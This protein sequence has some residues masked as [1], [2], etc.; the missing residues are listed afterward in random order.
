MAPDVRWYGNSPPSSVFAGEKK[1][2][3]DITQ[4]VPKLPFSAKF[5]FTGD[6]WDGGPGG[7]GMGGGWEVIQQLWGSNH[8]HREVSALMLS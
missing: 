5:L 2:K 8:T 4:P 7:R 3:I 1:K 6:V